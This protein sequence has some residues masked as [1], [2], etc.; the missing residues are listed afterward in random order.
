MNCGQCW[1]IDWRCVMR[2]IC[3]T[4]SE[5][6]GNCF[7]NISWVGRLERCAER[8][9]CTRTMKKW[10]LNTSRVHADECTVAQW[11]GWQCEW[12]RMYLNSHFSI[13]R[14]IS[15][16]ILHLCIG[17]ALSLFFLVFVDSLLNFRLIPLLVYLPV[18]STV[19]STSVIDFY[20]TRLMNCLKWY[21]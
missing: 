19:R 2:C 11:L 20:P 16:S 5:R 4:A 6:T 18:S 14:N 21:G 15:I 10:Y 17:I 9:Y 8:V 3:H 13:Y 12:N 1:H 7:S